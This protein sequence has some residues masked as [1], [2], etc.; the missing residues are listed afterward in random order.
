MRNPRI[1]QNEAFTVGNVQ[2]LSDDA[3]GH[4][5]R[6]LRL[7]DGDLITLFNGIAEQS[8]YFEYQAKRACA[9]SCN[10]T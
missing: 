4:A 8:V 6:V 10:E 1:F 5:V 9:P 7:K 3:F 2:P